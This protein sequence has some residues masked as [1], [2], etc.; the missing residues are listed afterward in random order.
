MP[1]EKM[2]LSGVRGMVNH[3][4]RT[5]GLV[6]ASLPQLL[7]ISPNVTCPPPDVLSVHAPGGVAVAVGDRRVPIEVERDGASSVERQCGNKR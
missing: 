3:D 6:P 5:S 2:M 4:A 7:P 1:W